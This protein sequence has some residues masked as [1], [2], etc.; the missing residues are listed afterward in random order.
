V[1]RRHLLALGA[2]L[3]L[4]AIT[5]PFAVLAQQPAKVHRI[6]I[7][8]NGSLG[9]ATAAELL[10]TFRKELRDLGYIEGQNLIIDLRSAEGSTQR[11]PILAADL[12]ALKPN[13]IVCFATN[14]ALATKKA[15]STVPVVMVQVGDPV[16]SG[17]VASLAHPGGNIT[18]VTDY[19]LDLNAKHVELVHAVVPKAARIG[20]LTADGSNDPRQVKAIE[21][22][23]RGVG[24]A[25]IPKMDRSDEELDRAFASW[26]KDGAGAVIVLG[27]VRHASERKK[28]AELAVKFGMPTI[29]PNRAYVD[30]G[31]LMSYGAN[32]NVTYKLAVGY[33]DKILKGAKPAD[34]P[35]EQPPTFELVINLKTAK[36]LGITI[37]QSLLLRA[38]KVI[39]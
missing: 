8:L 35:V 14:G 31:G 29:F 19:A 10:D 1:V 18:G 15:T 39:E 12:V 23:A 11:L 7:L 28:I 25:V 24:L 6:G 33:I 27:G 2:L 37:P 20:I 4:C 36:A 13:V 5:F 34:L 16:S 21:A 26:A 22:A 9:S 38:D 32:L 30:Q 3:G 17:L